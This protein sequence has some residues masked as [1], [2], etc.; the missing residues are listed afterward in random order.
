[1]H[2]QQEMDF[3]ARCRVHAADVPRVQRGEARLLLCLLVIR[4]QRVGI[5]GVESRS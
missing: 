5:I 3:K 2:D 4:H 1:M